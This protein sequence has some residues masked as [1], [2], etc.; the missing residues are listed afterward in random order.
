MALKKI[1]DALK[2]WQLHNEEVQ[3]QTTVDRSESHATKTA[4]IKRAR[5]DYAFFVELLFPS[6]CQNEIR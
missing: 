2:E 3:Q 4:R 6:F 1:T 5:K